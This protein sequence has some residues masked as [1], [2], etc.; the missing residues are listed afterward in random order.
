[1]HLIAFEALDSECQIRFVESFLPSWIDELRALL[2][3]SLIDSCGMA[4][5]YYVVRPAI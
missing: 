2:F 3:L 1:M 5:L 4:I